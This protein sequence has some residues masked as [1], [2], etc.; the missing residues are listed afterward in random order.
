M[1]LYMQCAAGLMRPTQVKRHMPGAHQLTLPKRSR[2]R[3]APT[4]TNISMNSE[5]EAEMKGT[6]ASPATAR[7][8][9]VLPVPG[10]PSI[11]TP[12]GT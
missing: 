2:T 10:G 11:K 1:H 9:R 3:D 5:P 4:P 8:K 7:A 6:P 12:R